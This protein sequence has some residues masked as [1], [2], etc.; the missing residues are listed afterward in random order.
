MQLAHILNE[1][2]WNT[3]PRSQNS[4]TIAPSDHI[5]LRPEKASNMVKLGPVT[6]KLRWRN[7][8]RTFPLECRKELHSHGILDMVTR[9]IH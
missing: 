6:A 5:F 3:A 8:R 2:S 7:V 1:L 4:S 9:S